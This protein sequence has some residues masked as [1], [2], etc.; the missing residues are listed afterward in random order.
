MIQKENLNKLTPYIWE[1]PVSF[2]ADM[3]VPTRIIASEEMLEELFRDKSIDQLVNVSTLPGI[4]KAAYVMPDVH[5][6]YGFPIGGLAATLYPDGVISPGGIGYDINC[7][8]RLLKT[9][10]KVRDIKGKESLLA[11]K[12]FEEIPSGVGKGGRLKPNMSQLDDV[13]TKGAGWMVENG[14]GSYDDLQFLESN[15]CL[16]EAE[17]GAVSE[18]A[19]LRGKDQ[20][21][22]LGSGNHFVE[23]ETVEEVYDT[24]IAEKFGLSAGQIVVLIHCGSRGLGHQVAT[25]YIRLMLQNLQK[26]GITLP[27]RELACAPLSSVEG[28]NYFGAMCAAANYAW[29]NRQMIAWEAGNVFSELFGEVPTTLYDVAHNIAK[30]EDHQIDG[31]LKKVI[32]HRKGATRAFGPGSHELSGE[33]KSTGQP[34]LIPGSMG[35]ASYVL[36]GTNE[37]MLEAFGSSCHGAGRKMSRHAALK[38]VEGQKLKAEL[39]YKGIFV[40]SGSLKGLAEEAP[41]A[42]KDVNEVVSVVKGAGIARKVAKLRPLVVIKG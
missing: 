10:L 33:F 13:L 3:R 20:L 22:T 5:E 38:K 41:L 31:E 35:T 8:V 37:G 6:G 14:Y 15:G 25:D 12:L 9:K 27:D 16:S 34:V 4:Q 30:I 42:Y 18:H 17:P 1:I 11:K 32:V 26:H 23:V 36:A 39:E 24:D 40:R 19:K 2:R 28:R 29:A 7:G 21:G